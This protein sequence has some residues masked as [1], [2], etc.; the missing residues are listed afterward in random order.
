MMTARA[1][2]VAAITEFTA[3][4]EGCVEGGNKIITHKRESCLCGESCEGDVSA[5]G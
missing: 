4:G 2:T 5:L 1:D 3:W